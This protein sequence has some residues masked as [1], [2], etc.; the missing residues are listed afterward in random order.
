MKCVRHQQE[1]HYVCLK[2]DCKYMIMCHQCK[3]KE[4]ESHP[5]VDF[6]DLKELNMIRPYE[7]LEL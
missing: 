3:N 1:A 4:H 6:M 7:D 2:P 5:F